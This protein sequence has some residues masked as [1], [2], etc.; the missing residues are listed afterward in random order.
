MRLRSKHVLPKRVVSTCTRLVDTRSVVMSH[1]RY[2]L[3][4]T[5]LRKYEFVRSLRNTVRTVYQRTTW[6]LQGIILNLH[7]PI[8]CILN[9]RHVLNMKDSTTLDNGRMTYGDVKRQRT[10]AGSI[11][12]PLNQIPVTKWEKRSPFEELLKGHKRLW[13]KWPSLS[14]GRL[15]DR[16]VTFENH[17]APC[18]INARTL[19]CRP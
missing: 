8:P 12:K 19:S 16:L 15:P 2:V 17:V 13:V 7:T 4:W 18:R 1:P 9:L 14:C 10:L 11:P 3:V 5:F 6:H